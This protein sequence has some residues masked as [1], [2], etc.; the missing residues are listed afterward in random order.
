MGLQEGNTYQQT[1]WAGHGPCDP[2]AVALASAA[3]SCC[4]VARDATARTG[5]G[6]GGGA[7][8]GTGEVVEA[9]KSNRWQF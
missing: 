9:P 7:D 8:A 6:A 4:A 2:F 3:D 1:S 5:E